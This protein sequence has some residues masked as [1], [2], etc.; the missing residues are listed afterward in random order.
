MYPTTT[1][2]TVLA[3]N[4]TFNGMS[5]TD[6][7]STEFAFAVQQSIAVVLALPVSTISL[8]IVTVAS[9]RRNLRVDPLAPTPTSLRRLLSTTAIASYT[10]TT[11][12][13]VAS[14]LT[15]ALTGTAAVAAVSASM[16]GLGYTSTTATT[17]VVANVSPLPTGGG[18]TAINV[19]AYNNANNG[20]QYVSAVWSTSTTCVMIGNNHDTPTI[21]GTILRTT[22]GGTTW[23]SVTVDSTAPPVAD[24]ATITIN[25][26]MYHIIAASTGN[27]YRSNDGGVTYT[28][29]LVYDLAVWGGVAIGS[30]GYLFVV[31]YQVTLKRLITPSRATQASTF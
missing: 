15:S 28:P 11:T 25:N 19:T 20:I 29:T 22:N 26:V 17:P 4:Q 9:A 21:T 7:L 24:I 14:T 5:N 31:G 27:I 10:I 8:P 3:V 12:N 16:Q 1:S 30:N 18:W 2:T 6:A 23:T 13:T